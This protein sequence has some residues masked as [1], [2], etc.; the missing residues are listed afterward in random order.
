[1]TDSLW[2]PLALSPAWHRCSIASINRNDIKMITS[3]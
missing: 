3:S 2:L 1:M